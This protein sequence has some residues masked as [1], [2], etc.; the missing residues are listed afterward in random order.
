MKPSAFLFHCPGAEYALDG[1]GHYKYES[2]YL[3][4]DQLKSMEHP[5][6]EVGV[7][8]RKCGKKLGMINTNLAFEKFT[9]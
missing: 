8:D 4:I 1:D 2:N 9:E 5:P 3:T 6:K 7:L